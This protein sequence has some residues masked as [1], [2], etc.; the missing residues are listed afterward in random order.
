M[1]FCR[2]LFFPTKKGV[3]Y[4]ELNRCR[5]RNVGVFYSK[6]FFWGYSASTKPL[7]WSPKLLFL[8]DKR[9]RMQTKSPVAW[10]SVC[11]QSSYSFLQCCKSASKIR[12]LSRGISQGL[13]DRSCILFMLTKTK[14]VFEWWTAWTCSST[15]KLDSQ[16]VL[17]HFI[18]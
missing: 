18:L 4:Q 3:Q 1:F 16:P 5:K 6:I 10:I 8:A 11:L 12:C 13:F 15:T 14:S 2:L 9:Y 7:K 17:L